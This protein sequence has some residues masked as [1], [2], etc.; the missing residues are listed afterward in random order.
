MDTAGFHEIDERLNQG[1]EIDAGDAG[2]VNRVS[3][4]LAATR[5]PEA[6]QAQVDPFQK[7]LGSYA[8]ALA[9]DN[10]E[11]AKPLAT[12]AHEQEHDLSHAV[13][14][15][16]GETANSSSTISPQEQ[17]FQVTIAAY[18]MDMADLHGMDERINQQETI[19][20]GDA[21]VVNRINQVLVVTAWPTELQAQ[22]DPLKESLSQYAEALANDGLETAKPLATQVHEQG[23]DLSHAIEGWLCQMGS[24]PVPAAD[25]H[26]HD[27]SE[28]GGD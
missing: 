19:D 1:G 25:E 3:Q 8:E 27:D 5:W 17:M 28:E 7:T 15:W 6:V 4:V 20:P 14:H 24:S 9:N 11:A 16:L 2:L 12:Q 13:E 10:L 22:V 23:H 18:L 26:D 21:G